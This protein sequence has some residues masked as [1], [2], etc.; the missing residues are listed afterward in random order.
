MRTL[1]IEFTEE[2]GRLLPK[3]GH[4]LPA[5]FKSKNLKPLSLRLNSTIRAIGDDGING[6]WL[7]PS[8]VVVKFTL[9]GK[10]KMGEKK[11]IAELSSDEF[12]SI[13]AYV[14]PGKKP[15]KER[16]RDARKKEKATLQHQD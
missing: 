11:F 5:C 1:D 6:P 12:D 7:H 15:E 4:K 9:K 16:P 10:N 2:E 14:S 8:G 3:K 13:R